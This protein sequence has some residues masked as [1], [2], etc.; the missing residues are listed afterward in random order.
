MKKS[1]IILVSILSMIIFVATFS[2]CE[3]ANLEE[4]K[5]EK[6]L[7]LEK[8]ITNYGIADFNTRATNQNLEVLIQNSNDREDEKIN[9]YLYYLMHSLKELTNYT[10]FNELI[11]ESAKQNYFQT[12]NL[13][14]VVNNNKEIGNIINEKLKDN[15]SNL[16]K[17][18]ESL[19]EIEEKLTYNNGR[20]IEKYT[21]VIYV[22][23]LK[24]CDPT[25]NPLFAIS[26]AVNSDSDESI[27]ENIIAYYYDENQNLHKTLLSESDIIKIKNPIFII[28]NGAINL[29][30]PSIINTEISNTEISNTQKTSTY[31]FH[32]HEYRIN[33][34]YENSGKSEFCI[35]AG[36]VLGPSDGR[37]I[38]KK[39]GKLKE[40]KE[41]AS[42]DK[43]DIG[44]DLA[45]REQFCD[46]NK[47]DR[48]V[49][50]NTFER[51]WYSSSKSLGQGGGNNGYVY[52][53][54]NMKYKSNWYSFD[55][56][57]L[58]TWVNM[59]HIYWSWAQWYKNSKSEFRIWR[60]N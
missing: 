4:G 44:K 2:S 42:V 8:K 43:N 17:K 11:L 28:D 29:H 49:F 45:H 15:T 22:P 1:K 25:K 19:Q 37:Y 55:P 12:A 54:G 5:S 33:H 20:T 31:S 60:C 24:N 32:S 23:N 9:S 41:I 6:S 53:Y 34:R 50:F 36:I 7:K 56:E 13:I 18:V 39:N 46:R 30:K 52:L 3:K 59:N 57:N 47:D 51:D 40:W 21:P 14:T 16:D 58:T 10:K 38:L 27:E 26:V 35:T 48:Y